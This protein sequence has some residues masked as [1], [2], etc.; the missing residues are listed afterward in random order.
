RRNRNLE[1]LDG[2]FAE[3]IGN[4]FTTSFVAKVRAGGAGTIHCKGI[5]AI[6]IGVASIFSPL[7]TRKANEPGLPIGAGVGGEQSE[8]SV[9]A[10]TERKT[11]EQT[12]RYHGTIRGIC[13]AEHGSGTEDNDALHGGTGLK[14]DVGGDC[15]THRN[16]HFGALRGA[17]SFEGY[18]ERIV[19]NSQC[20]KEEKSIRSGEALEYGSGTLFTELDGRTRR[21]GATGIANASSNGPRRHHSLRNSFQRQRGQQEEHEK[22]R[23]GLKPDHGNT[24]TPKLAACARNLS[25]IRTPQ[26]PQTLRKGILPRCSAKRPRWRKCGTVECCSRSDLLKTV[27]FPSRRQSNARRSRHRWHRWN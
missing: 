23:T 26:T 13:C 11:I 27:Q 24:P 17:K 25:I 8:I 14:R 3:N 18:L 6:P 1:F 16:N 5:G 19:A 15:L 9:A 21:R 10:A 12:A 20:R 4:A 7:L 2:I 22:S